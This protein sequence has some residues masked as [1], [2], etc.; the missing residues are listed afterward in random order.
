MHLSQT[1]TRVYLPDE[2]GDVD[3]NEGGHEV[4]AVEPVHD[5]SV[6][7]DGVGKIL[8]GDRSSRCACTTGSL[9]EQLAFPSTLILNALLKPLAKKPPNGPTMEAKLERAM[10]WIWKG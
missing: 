1:S 9:S 10:L 5:A 6:T 2:T 8:K 7:R 4:L 3:V